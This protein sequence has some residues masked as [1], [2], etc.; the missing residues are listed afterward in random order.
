MGDVVEND[1][2]VTNLKR[3]GELKTGFKDKNGKSINFVYGMM[4]SDVAGPGVIAVER[5]VLESSM[6]KG[7]LFDYL[8]KGW[9][10]FKKINIQGAITGV[11]YD[12]KGIASN[13]LDGTV[14]AQGT[15]E[16][17]GITEQMIDK[18]I[19]DI[20]VKAAQA[21]VAQAAQTTPVVQE[22]VLVPA[23]TP[24]KVEVS[25]AGTPKASTTVPVN[26]V[27]DSAATV[28]ADVNGVLKQRGRPK[29]AVNVPDSDIQNIDEEPKSE[30]Q[31][32]TQKDN[33]N[34]IDVKSGAETAAAEKPVQ[35]KKSTDFV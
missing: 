28:T 16:Q 2:V 19:N 7:L 11:A 33:N 23:N 27:I 10:A 14:K 24:G 32:E 34:L 1:L 35:E 22:P 30:P 4:L 26:N 25:E 12:F 18:T 13:E 6:T 29:K 3:A 15:Q 5:T 31:T 8:R 20:A 9:V 21:K 17:K